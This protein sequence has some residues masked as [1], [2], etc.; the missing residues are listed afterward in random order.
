MNKWMKL[1]S[2]LLLASIVVSACSLDRK[3]VDMT[4]K[5]TVMDEGTKDLMDETTPENLPTDVIDINPSDYPKPSE[6]KI[7]EMLTELQYDVTQNDG[8]ERA[9]QNEYNDNKEAGIYVDIVTGEPLFS[10]RDKYDS[11]TGWPSFTKPISEE[12]IVKK[13]DRSLFGVRVEARSRIGDSHLGHIFDDGPSDRGGLRYCM[14]S[15]SLKFIPKEEMEEMGY[16]YLIVE[17][18]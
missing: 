18:E 8:T 2:V 10:S 13:E 5:D 11:H 4:V 12:V 16:G 3:E 17:V 9:F 7:K 15:A 6:D 14:N 1:V